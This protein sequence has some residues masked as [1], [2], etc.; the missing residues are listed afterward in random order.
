ME[1]VT[2]A[3][4]IRPHKRTAQGKMA[5]APPGMPEGF[6][7][8]APSMSSRLVRCGALEFNATLREK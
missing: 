7:D 3:S 2:H 4:D 5:I 6:A 1:D 8:D